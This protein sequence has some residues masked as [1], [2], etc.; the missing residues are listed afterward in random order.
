[1]LTKLLL[2]LS[3]A[4]AQHS[5]LRFA[6]FNPSEMKWTLMARNSK[7]I[8]K[9][10]QITLRFRFCRA[11]RFFALVCK[12]IKIPFPTGPASAKTISFESEAF[13]RRVQTDLMHS[14]LI[15]CH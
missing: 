6:D 13:N 10:L 8:F 5:R 1:M 14:A 15:F 7:K 11:E 3:R 2:S 12:F 9:R 4:R